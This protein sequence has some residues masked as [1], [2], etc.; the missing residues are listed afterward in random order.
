MELRFLVLLYPL[1]IESEIPIR[2]YYD[3]GASTALLP[4]LLR[5]VSFCPKFQIVAELPSGS[6]MGGLTRSS[7]NKII[8]PVFK[9]HRFDFPNHIGMLE[10]FC[11]LKLYK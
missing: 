7:L 5:F 8:H 11:N 9:D 2:F 3:Q 6:G 4:Y 10:N 1:Y